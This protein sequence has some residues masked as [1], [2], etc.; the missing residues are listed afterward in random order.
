[1]G[2]SKDLFMQERAKEYETD[3]PLIIMNLPNT[4][5]QSDD[6]A[7][8]ELEK[9]QNGETEA[10]KT[11]IK[12]KFLEESLEGLKEG[13]KKQA[14]EEAERIGKS[15]D[16]FGVKFQIK[17]AGTKYDYS[18]CNDHE[19]TIL[20]QLSK[21]ASDGLTARQKFLKA[22]PVGKEVYGDDGVQLFPPI[23]SST[24]TLAITLPK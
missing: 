14:L 8:K 21:N 24:T 7:V 18:G 19:L 17:E 9:V 6:F 1:M 22:I 5:S 11:W 4:K 23:K 12:I 2:A 13:I 20:E 3:Q 10:L 15:G 16:Y